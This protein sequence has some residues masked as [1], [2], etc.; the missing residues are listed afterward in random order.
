MPF[1]NMQTK[2]CAKCDLEKSLYEFYVRDETGRRRNECKACIRKAGITLR[3]RNR[4]MIRQR[5]KAHYLEHRD[6]LL[7]KQNAYSAEHRDQEAARSKKWR[8]ENPDKLR[9]VNVSY[10]ARFKDKVLAQK[11]EYAMVNRE[12]L[13]VISRRRKALIRSTASVPITAAQRCEAITYYGGRC[14]Y[15]LTIPNKLTWDHLIPISRG[16]RHEL[17]NIVPACFSCNGEKHKRTLLEYVA[18][19]GRETRRMEMSLAAR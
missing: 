7:A 3:Q 2:R 8:K 14:A 6:Q 16:G 11:R 19:K 10:Y 18:F 9:Q 13:R 12:A 1:A 4:E 15:C 5:R 17:S